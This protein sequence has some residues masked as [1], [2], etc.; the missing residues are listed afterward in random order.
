MIV[1]AIV[2]LIAQ[3]SV[4][5]ASWSISDRLGIQRSDVRLLVFQF[6]RIVLVSAIVLGFGAFR[7][8]TV[9]ILAIAVCGLLA[10]LWS[11]GELKRLPYCR[12]QAEARG[13]FLIALL[14]GARLL[15]QVWYFA[16]HS[17]D[18]LSYHLPKVA[19]W[20]RTG[21]LFSELGVDDH[22]TFP[23][24][25]ELLES[26]WT[27]FLRHDVLIEMAGVEFLLLGVSATRSMGVS[28]GL[29]PR[30]AW[31]AGLLYG[32]TPGMYWQATSCLN[33][34]AVAAVFVTSAALIA[35]YAPLP[36]VLGAVALG[37]GIKATFFFMTPGLLVMS[38][39]MRRLPSELNPRPSRN[40]V[41]ILVLAGFVGLFWYA[42]NWIRFGSPVY[43]MGVKMLPV[44]FGPSVQSFLLNAGDLAFRRIDDAAGPYG[45]FLDQISGWGAV[46]VGCGLLALLTLVREAPRYR[47]VAIPFLIA[48]GGTL[49]MVAHDDWFMRFLLF[50]PSILAIAAVEIFGR[51]PGT[52][53][54]GGV[55]GASLILGTMLP[56]DLPRSTVERLARQPWRERS[57]AWKFRAELR[58]PR[59]GYLAKNRGPAYLLYRPDFSQEVAYLRSTSAE[60]L[61][62]ELSDRDVESVYIAALSP[63]QREALLHLL[64]S[65]DLRPSGRQSFLVRRP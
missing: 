55:A 41:P 29:A 42:R 14:L 16:P 5:V 61:R 31:V 11:F 52:L 6:V 13:L 12:I 46:G 4:S 49:L 25:F 53:W 9:P 28:L 48:V 36:L 65:G 39:W 43:P 33:D 35:A 45:A 50:F 47:A 18:T 7:L 22:S 34:G 62:K 63:L 20:I 3:I 57:M 37:V 54:M 27:I 2:L 38:W 10:I 60:A 26:W 30:P 56:Y 44:Q 15:L 23:A 24:G 51:H 19:E 17:V 58:S 32:L 1:G 8:L 64:R 21:S 40:S 59:V